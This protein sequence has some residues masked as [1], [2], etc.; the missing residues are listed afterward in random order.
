[1]KVMTL[2]TSFMLALV[3]TI[4]QASELEGFTEPYRQVAVPAAEIG[5]IAEILVVEGDQVSERQL[6]A[7][8]DDSVLQASL[9]VA[10]AA[11]DATGARRGA[12]AE[13]A[14]REK[15]LE[16]Y[17]DLHD[18]G[19]ASQREIDRSESEY[20]QAASRLQSVRDDLEVRRLEFERVKSQIRRRRIES[21]ISGHV[22]SIVKES[23]EF[24]SPT[25]PIVMQVVQL[26]VLKAVFS[27]PIPAAR[28]LQ[29]QDTVTLLVGAQQIACKGQIEFISP[30]ADAQSGSVR[31]KIRIP[32]KDGLIPSGA[33]CRWE[34][35]T[36]LDSTE[37]PQRITTDGTRRVR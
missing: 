6:L 35:E 15:Q 34:I 33:A 24:V 10:R 3:P 20:Q 22:I 25:D 37:S 11:K 18:K 17:R 16:G 5:V 2:A 8:L 14:V 7:R 32:N 26:D 4:A 28:E 9:Q 29:K 1:M 19:N 13:L 27:V 36:E 23:G 31:V 30:T 12:E 21:P